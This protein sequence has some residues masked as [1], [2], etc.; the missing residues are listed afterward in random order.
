MKISQAGI[1]LI[2]KFEGCRLVAYRDAV[3]VLTIGYGHT[4]SVR[5]AQRINQAEAEAL[6]RQDLE[7]F[8]KGVEAAVTVPLNQNQFDAL[9]S[10]SFNLGLGNLRKST[11]LDYVNAKNFAAAAKEFQ[12]WDKAGGRVLLGLTRRREAEAALFSKAVPV[13]HKPAP[14]KPAHKPEPK[15]AH[16]PEPK[17]AHKPAPVPKPGY[18]V[19]KPGDA[20]GKLAAKYGSTLAQIKAWNH[21][22]DKYVIRVGQKLRV[23]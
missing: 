6:L 22:N 9:V 11:L 15:P 14:V 16:K 8:E 1:D 5:T 4:N 17:P 7:E 2:K 23:K 20:V 19:V 18:H 13:A 10:F 21:L 3:N 12:R